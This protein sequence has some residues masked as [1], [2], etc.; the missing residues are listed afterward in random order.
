M[1]GRYKS[2]ER[3]VLVGS[4]Y[5]I[6]IGV[7]LALAIALV[8]ILLVFIPATEDEIKTEKTIVSIED[9][10]GGIGV[11]SDLSL[12]Y[13]TV[14]YSDGTTE[15]VPLASTVFEGLDLTVP[16]TNNVV[17]S[18]GGFE[19]SV[20]F[21]V[22]A[23]DCV[24][25]Y[26]SSVG[27]SIRGEVQQSVKNGGSTSTV[28]A[29]PET[30]YV[31]TGWKDGYPYA[32]RKDTN[33]VENK[34]IIASFEKAKYTVR[35]YFNDGTVASEEKVTFGEAATKAPVPGADPRMEVYG[36]TFNT[37]V[38]NDYSY[39]DRDMNIYPDYIKTATDVVMTVPNDVYGNAMGSVDVN[40]QG[41]YPHGKTATILASPYNSRK[42]S[43]WIITDV[44]GVEHRVDADGMQTVAVG[45][46][47][48]EL[49]FT[50]QRSGNSPEDYQLSFVPNADITQINVQAHFAYSATDITFV[51]YQQTENNGVVYV[52][53]DLPFGRPLWYITERIE[54]FKDGLPYPEDIKGLEFL[55]WYVFGDATQTVIDKE[56]TFSQ[57]T[58]LVAKWKRRQYSLEF[59]ADNPETGKYEA[60]HVTVVTYQDAFASGTNGGLP[61]GN[62]SMEKYN[63]IGWQDA[64]TGA[65]VD[66]RTQLYYD[67][68]YETTEDFANGVIKFIPVWE[69]KKHRLFVQLNGSGKATLIIDDNKVDADGESLTERVELNGEYIFAENRTYKLYIEALEGYELTSSLWEYNNITPAVREYLTGTFSDTFLINMTSDNLISVNLSV[70]NLNI[71][72]INGDGRYAG[73]VEYNGG[74]FDGGE[75]DFSVQYGS[76]ANFKIISYNP[77]YSI[78]GIKINGADMGIADLQEFTLVLSAIKN[79]TTVEISYY[80]RNYSLWIENVT[81][82]EI[83]FTD[84]FDE[85]KEIPFVFGED[86]F[87]AYGDKVYLRIKAD[88]NELRNVLSYLRINGI[89]CDLYADTLNDITLY[90]WQINGKPTNVG[91]SLIN[92]EY[93][94]VYGRENYD[95]DGTDTVCL[96]AETLQGVDTVFA[97]RIVGED[98]VF[99]KIP[100]EGNEILYSELSEKLSVSSRSIFNTAVR[101]DS[102][103]TS[104]DVMIN[105]VNN[106]N[107][108]LG[109]KPINYSVTAVAGEGI[110][111][112]SDPEPEFGGTSVLTATPTAGY[113]ISGYRINGGE[114]QVVDYSKKGENFSLSL[115]DIAEDKEVEFLFSPITFRV[116]FAHSNIA[117]NIG[118]VFVDGEKLNDSVLMER[119]YH[120]TVTVT[121]TAE[122]ARISAIIVNGE[123][124]SVHYNMTSYVFTS[125]DL[126]DNVFVEILT[127]EKES[128][129]TE[130]YY[131]LDVSQNAVSGNATASAE[132][133]KADYSKANAVKVMADYGYT[134]NY[135]DVRTKN[136][137]KILPSAVTSSAKG[138]TIFEFEIPANFFAPGDEVT[139]RVEVAP[140]EYALHTEGVG[141]GSISPSRRVLYGEEETVEITANAN[142]YIYA[143]YL[144]GEAISF[145]SSYWNRLIKNSSTGN[146]TSAVFA[147]M[148]ETD[149]EIKAV[150]RRNTY[151]VTVDDS[152]VNGVTTLSVSKNDETE[153]GSKDVDGIA[154]GDH[155]SYIPYG[156]FLSINMSAEAGYH[157]AGLSVNDV[158]MELQYSGDDINEY[159]SATFVYRG[160][161]SDGKHLGATGRLNV[162]VTY[163]INKYSFVYSIVNA[164]KN[165]GS[166]LN[167]GT[168]SSVYPSENNSF[169]GIE[170][171]TN[172]YFNV[173]PSVGNGYYLKQIRML[174]KSAYDSSVREIIHVPGDNALAEITSRGG[175]IWFNRFLE[176][177]DGLTADIE[178][179]E[180]TFDRNL[181]T[182]EL[183]QF[184]ASDTGTMDIEF[185]HTGA[186]VE[187]AILYDGEGNAYGYKE[188]KF[189]P[190]NGTQ[191]SETDAGITLQNENGKY[192][193]KRNGRTVDI[194][195]EH[196]LRY[197]VFVTPTLGYERIMFTVNGDDNLSRV[198]SN[199][200][201]TNIDRA[202][203]INVQYRILTYDVSF[204]ITVND[205]NRTGTV[206]VSTIKDYADIF[207]RIADGDIYNLDYTP[208]TGHDEYFQLEYGESAITLSLSGKGYKIGYGAKIQFVMVPKF[209]QSG[210]MLSGFVMGGD[211]TNQV[212]TATLVLPEYGEREV[213]IFGGISMTD[214]TRDGYVVTED[215]SARSTF[216]VTRY[217]VTTEIIY[218]DG[219]ENENANYLRQETNISVAWGESS[220]IK[221]YVSE[222]FVLNDIFFKRGDNDVLHK[223]NL[224]DSA[225]NEAF[226]EQMYFDVY[227]PA[228]RETRDFLRIKK[229]ATKIYIYAHLSREE[230]TVRYV[231][232]DTEGNP[233]QGYLDDISTVYNK[234]HV[235]YPVSYD[236]SSSIDNIANWSENVYS[237]PASYYDE[238]E[239]TVTPKNGY[240]VMPVTEGTSTEYKIIIRAVKYDES[241]NEWIYLKDNSGNFI[242]TELYLTNLDGDVNYFTFHP[243][244]SPITSTFISS[245]IEIEFTLEVKTYDVSTSV[246]F[247]NAISSNP[248]SV[249]RTAVAWQIRDRNSDQLSSATLS[250]DSGAVTE[251]AEHHGTLYY[252]F[253]ATSGYRLTMISI[254]GI[255]WEGIETEWTDALTSETRRPSYD[256]SSNQVS[257][258]AN[259]L[260]YTVRYNQVTKQYVYEITFT[261]NDALVKGNYAAVQTSLQVYI[262]IAPISYDIKAYI[263]GELLEHSAY[264]GVSGVSDEKT[265][266]INLPET[267]SHFDRFVVTPTA[268]EGYEIRTLTVLSGGEKGED[269]TGFTVSNPSGRKTYDATYI[270]LPNVNILEGK[271]S[272]HIFYTTGIVSYKAEV[273]A[274]AYSYG[275]GVE[276][277]EGRNGTGTVSA[278]LSE[279]Y[280]GFDTDIGNVTVTIRTNNVDRVYPNENGYE[281]FSEVTIEAYANSGYVLYDVLE[282]IDG[283]E[284]SVSDGI[285]GVRYYTENRGET[286]KYV[287]KY[288]VDG[289]GDRRF[290]VV[291]KQKTT[292]TVHVPH[293]YKYVTGDGIG[294]NVYYA[295]VSLSA[296]ENGVT[297]PNGYIDVDS[298]GTGNIVVYYT[299]KYDVLAGNYF[300][301]TYRELQS[302][303][304][305]SD[306]DFYT[307]YVGDDGEFVYEN[308]GLG[309]NNANYPDGAGITV[310]GKTELYLLAAIDTR[311]TFDKVTNGAIEGAE[312]GI[313]YFNNSGVEPSLGAFYTSTLNINKDTKEAT[314][315]TLEIT[316]KPNEHYVVSSLSFRQRNDKASKENGR[317]VFNEG[318]SEWL[319]YSESFNEQNTNDY[320]V[321]SFV[322]NADG[323]LHFVIRL[324]GDMEI[325]AEFYRV[326]EFSYG[327]HYADKE[328]EMDG[329]S[330]EFESILYNEY[331]GETDGKFFVQYG[332]IVKL[333]APVAPEN[334]LFVGW[335]LNDK[336]TF[337]NLD[338]AL[339]RS[340]YSYELAI[341]SILDGLII[342]GYEAEKFVVVARYQP[343]ISVAVVNESYYY[344]EQDNHWN[345]WTSGLLRTEY[346]DYD[347]YKVAD[348][349]TQTMVRNDDTVTVNA[350]NYG[351]LFG[352]SA[353]TW[354]KNIY[355]LAGNLSDKEVHSSARCFN[356][357]YQSITNYDLIGN[358]WEEGKVILKIEAL[359]VDIKLIGWQYYNW[360]T[361][362]FEDITYF[363]TDSGYG[364][365]AV[366]DNTFETYS[367]ALSY[368][369]A[370]TSDG[371]VLMP[372]AVSEEFENNDGWSKPLIIRPYLHKIVSVELSQI[373]YVDM[374]KG[375]TTEDF[376]NIIHPVISTVPSTDIYPNT[377]SANKMSATYDYGTTINLKYYN[378][379]DSNNEVINYPLVEEDGDYNY[380]YRFIGWTL[381]WTSEGVSEYRFINDLSKSA[382]IDGF[383][384]DLLYKFGENPPATTVQ[385]EAVYIIQY[386]QDFYSYNVAKSDA[387]YNEA[388]GLSREDAPAITIDFNALKEVV[389]FPFMDI[390]TRNV[391]TVN[392]GYENTKLSEDT[393][394]HVLQYL[395][396]V[397]CRYVIASEYDKRKADA[398]G[399]NYFGTAAQRQDNGKYQGYDPDFDSFYKLYYNGEEQKNDHSYTQKT[400]TVTDVFQMDLQ[401]A[402]KGIIVFKNMIYGSGVTVPEVLSRYYNNGRYVPMTIWDVDEQYGDENIDV[403]FNQS[404]TNYS[405][406]GYVVVSIPQLVNVT[407]LN[408]QFNYALNGFAAGNG[409]VSTRMYLNYSYKENNALSYNGAN[410]FNPSDNS[411]RRYI[412]I[413]YNDKYVPGDTSL[414]FGDPNYSG[415]KFSV[416]NTGFG[417]ASNPY[418]IFNRQQLINMSSF[419]YANDNTCVINNKN[420]TTEQVYFKLFS[421]I[422][423]QTMSSNLINVV[424][425]ADGTEAWVP[426]TYAYD[427][428]DLGFDGVFD[429]N[430]HMLYGLAAFDGGDPSGSAL[431]TNIAKTDFDIG[432]LQGYGIFG[433]INGGT[434]KNLYI[435]DAFLKLTHTDYQNIGVLTAK[436]I[437]AN[438]SN[439]TFIQNA[440]HK[441]S[442]SYTMTSYG[443]AR[444]YVNANA[445]RVGLLAGY[446]IGG[447]IS[448]ITINTKD[449]WRNGGI[450]TNGVKGGI[451]IASAKSS[452]STTMAN[453][454]N[455]YDGVG[456]LVGCAVGMTYREYNA[457]GELVNS[458]TK[459][460]YSTIK[461]EGYGSTYTVLN[462]VSTAL[463][464]GGFIGTAANGV[465][466][467]GVNVTNGNITIGNKESNTTVEI[468]GGIVG[469]TIN[470]T[471]KNST[472]RSYNTSTRN[473]ERQGIILYSRDVAGGIIGEH[474]EI[475]TTNGTSA[476]VENVYYYGIL[477]T[478]GQK[479][480]GIV[481]LNKG[482]TVKNI[483]LTAP[484]TSDS[485]NGF[486]LMHDI[487]DS[488]STD[489]SVGGIVGQ[490]DGLVHDCGI[491]G[492]ANAGAYNLGYAY[493]GGT[494]IYVYNSKNGNYTTVNSV[495]SRL[496]S[497][498][499]LLQ[500]KI[501]VGGIAGLS[502]GRVYNSYL[503]YTRLTVKLDTASNALRTQEDLTNGQ[504]QY[505]ISSGGIVGTLATTYGEY[506]LKDSEIGFDGEIQWN[507]RIADD[508]VGTRVQSCYTVN[509]SIVVANRIWVDTAGEPDELQ[510]D[511]KPVSI[512]VAGI[513]GMVRGYLGAYGINT[514]YSYNDRFSIQAAAY[515]RNNS[516]DAKDG[517]KTIDYGWV[518]TKNSFGPAIKAEYTVIRA[519][520][521]VNGGA[522]G[523]VGAEHIDMQFN[524][525]NA[526]CNYCWC[527]GN[528]LEGKASTT[529]TSDVSM[530][531]GDLGSSHY[532]RGIDYQSFVSSKLVHSQVNLACPQGPTGMSLTSSTVKITGMEVGWDKL[533]VGSHTITDFGSLNVL[534]GGGF[535]GVYDPAIKGGTDG[536]VYRTDPATGRLMVARMFASDPIEGYRKYKD[537]DEDEENGEN[538]GTDKFIDGNYNNFIAGDD[539]LKYL[540][541]GQPNAI[542]N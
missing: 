278:N 390:A 240:C 404:G 218:D 49:T 400:Y 504:H 302:V 11:G 196:G 363:Y 301:L 259:G 51:N 528:T 113:Y 539:Y 487:L 7:V 177:N 320:S 496:S 64:L 195:V 105:V 117:D 478:M 492:G 372:Y 527:K 215:I 530:I 432:H 290:K 120:T 411:Y 362:K 345:S 22:K 252:S 446:T 437:N 424:N 43:H 134:I 115:T 213:H 420:G 257:Y 269:A 4:G 227:N 272:V 83:F 101:K 253:T 86:Y 354:A 102:R 515:G 416:Y 381:Y 183:Q 521:Q 210:Y 61:H 435:G 146:Y 306:Y 397:G 137:E 25:K 133:I 461:Y 254:N 136:S 138:E 489:A 371:T 283:S 241:K 243:S 409:F 534:F 386:R 37:W 393:E 114:K 160:N 448:N 419:F 326:Y 457:E 67:A 203:V 121:I 263:N 502:S 455:I 271:L 18:Y 124:I 305:Q 392:L 500:A 139:V 81:G 202:L 174:Y 433:T 350:L 78:S 35:F 235:G 249:N 41:Y 143:V 80:T 450:V 281:Y 490:N 93:Y 472:L 337:V 469:T 258:N 505:V 118:S 97:V 167:S 265:A 250:R 342:N 294:N 111:T 128:D 217:E 463:S 319:A 327:I 506:E 358:N 84:I 331:A 391:S 10:S 377:R 164:S 374:L 132:F 23:V 321:K 238:L 273:D 512:T 264:D 161:L 140:I 256:P 475:A 66:D 9:A 206:S 87:Y 485:D 98:E 173:T 388:A 332:A 338:V 224:V 236:S 307:R 169:Y 439:I 72:L 208:A 403:K 53:Q 328:V 389:S 522:Y 274:Y 300:A 221:V 503:N 440:D 473:N 47:G 430:N 182:V 151:R 536:R 266:K 498:G 186:D 365:G 329:S 494:S 27:G 288:T 56:A 293:A 276:K 214:V 212:R 127:A 408:G 533:T 351:A 106:Y 398:D 44:N 260:A 99:T 476:V 445:D 109:F 190:Y 518:R 13:V 197:T 467:T 15:S 509:T 356:V 486:R 284:I 413:D 95:I 91:L 33:V 347:G 364:S 171:G 251:K 1:R 387:G 541:K 176:T 222:G 287:V 380:R 89:I 268:Y 153:E 454:V 540:V 367:F 412:V 344:S 519:G 481:G 303:G 34:T 201:A 335:Y 520:L 65:M 211:R 228:T 108:S 361:G 209:S 379:I 82:G 456:M 267:I 75:M 542:A 399:D 19:Q 28:V 223:V 488:T 339:P 168:V 31:F 270:F 468:A 107:I 296:Q 231:F 192:V 316:V 323:S 262:E 52:A 150:F 165:F 32:T 77:I 116:V 355:K 507:E 24:V 482:G 322:K 394:T 185:R 484:T 385:I 370:K 76:S 172:F 152:S 357:L 5:K 383:D 526:G 449:S 229:V 104:V 375:I 438:I 508:A 156:W 308:A 330:I 188:G 100:H 193:F 421:D 46:A 401:Y 178:L 69:A 483:Y 131:T 525:K 417:T 244:T 309:K 29:V 162:K 194:L 40:S 313:V 426:L 480:G 123:A 6:A 144:N 204:A 334:Y 415:E 466:I 366:V 501:N 55:G 135:V 16:G 406:N 157:I 187:Y 90:N 429:G 295:Y 396:D 170:H 68:R 255:T 516:E 346:Y 42:F 460:N 225:D 497:P 17:L 428:G 63:F 378:A 175:S 286:V 141:E 299:Y 154:D 261:V 184:S 38:P 368:L 122:N 3:R 50:S 282:N 292:V 248:D 407:N 471:V 207:I 12:V 451:Y 119:T 491:T 74:I 291:F 219:V 444:L 462:P 54:T 324:C 511:V 431:P 126:S 348:M 242:T 189:Y 405:N 524:N 30:G 166:D 427:N 158:E 343:I 425:P 191:F 315:K 125:A 70:R 62:P 532:V 442:T 513:V 436:A 8:L 92:G 159:R 58:T 470:S 310:E 145:T 233:A 94:Y 57:P 465:I 36:Y 226:D 325:R 73:H 220:D 359:P 198:N 373:A 382:D 317:I 239:A 129:V 360:N 142:C 246:S 289:L 39:V 179:I 26:E 349:P 477:R 275:D 110:V 279:G 418:R 529:K 237:L 60:I 280:I 514:C 384:F 340:A 434:V 88:E 510:A 479:V 369:F 234:N 247:I 318:S 314:Y 523:I 414:V 130:N 352:I 537:G 422:A 155:S 453:N 103:I 112:I 441:F 85:D 199:R 495:T 71:E 205:K 517:K 531:E 443:G 458:T 395:I 232:K 297:L 181:Y 230:Y 312:G 499:V 277:S 464:T 2:D 148:P 341:N 402:S 48:Q 311:I 163:E 147:F 376:S 245:D 180:V 59:W 447:T 149:M 452:S 459:A 216:D 298:E 493:L 336:N 304:K 353:E 285:R 200:Y 538:D 21:E 474:R 333:R 410:L 96:Y 535:V 79:D 20:T 14:T 45:V 423:L